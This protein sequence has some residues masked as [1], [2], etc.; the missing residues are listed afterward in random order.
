L[1]GST[2]DIHLGRFSL[3]QLKEANL[4]PRK[5]ATIKRAS[6]GKHLAMREQVLA[7]YWYHTSGAWLFPFHHA[8][9]KLDQVNKRFD[10]K[11][12]AVRTSCTR[13]GCPR[14][15]FAIDTFDRQSTFV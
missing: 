8:A 13:A 15:D 4:H 11:P 6:T 10:P 3:S 9:I 2:S 1:T 7:M 14:D 12:D 5:V